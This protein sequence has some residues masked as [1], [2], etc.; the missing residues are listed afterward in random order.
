MVYVLFQSGLWYH[1]TLQ[2]YFTFGFLKVSSGQ[3][4]FHF[5]LYLGEFNKL[6][7]FFVELQSFLF[8]GNLWKHILKCKK[9]I[10]NGQ[11]LPNVD[12]EHDKFAKKVSFFEVITESL[13]QLTLSNIIIRIYGVSDDSTTKFFQLFSLASSMLSLM[14]SFITVS[15]VNKS[16]VFYSSSHNI[17]V[18]TSETNVLET[19][20][21]A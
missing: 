10:T 11:D 7:I 6:I 20:D 8:S 5:L 19:I 4:L 12:P 17:Y 2:L 16:V 3:R 1:L 15:R 14:V 21:N 9:A 18:H 13:P